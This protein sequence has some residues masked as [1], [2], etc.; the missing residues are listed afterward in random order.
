[1]SPQFY[2]FISVLRRRMCVKKRTETVE[3]VSER[4]CLM[5][6]NEMIVNR[7]TREKNP[8]SRFTFSYKKKK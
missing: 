4:M 7:V 6:Y 5:T 1:M 2:D 3:R 8:S